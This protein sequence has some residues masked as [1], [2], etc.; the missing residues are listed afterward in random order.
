MAW[1][2]V[3]EPRRE[4]GG[5]QKLSS[6]RGPAA[7]SPSSH[8]QHPL[9]VPSWQP[10]QLVLCPVCHL[11][12]SP[13]SWSCR[14]PVRPTEGDTHENRR[15]RKPSAQTPAPRLSDPHLH[16]GTRAHARAPTHA[17]THLTHTHLTL[18]HTHTHPM[19]FQRAAV[20]QAW[21]RPSGAR[22]RFVV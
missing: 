9:A 15:P 6:R 2:W 16:T 8:R 3:P 22:S 1:T 11:E 14:D 5:T 13:R 4:N 18:T 10:S 17:C 21:V 19:R 20:D 7:L 12:R